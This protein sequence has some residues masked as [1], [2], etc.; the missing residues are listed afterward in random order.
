M[1][2]LK[3]KS[4][5]DLFQLKDVQRKNLS[6]ICFQCSTKNIRWFYFSTPL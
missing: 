2:K 1:F 6:Q 3:Q 5:I 4:Q